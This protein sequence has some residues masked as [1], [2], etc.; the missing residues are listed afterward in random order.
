MENGKENEENLM[1]MGEGT[2]QHDGEKGNTNEATKL[3][4]K[5]SKGLKISKEEL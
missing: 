4:G 3:L 1:A 2:I 5:I